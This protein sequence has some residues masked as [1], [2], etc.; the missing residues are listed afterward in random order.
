MK[1]RLALPGRAPWR[2][3]R[4]ATSPQG[5]RARGREHLL[6]RSSGGAEP[7]GPDALKAADEVK[8][9]VLEALEKKAAQQPGKE[10]ARR[11]SGQRTA[12]VTGAI[13]I[14]LGVA[15]LVLVQL[16]DTRG[17]TL[18]PPPPEAYGP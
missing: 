14:F 1:R 10:G 11:E 3:V 13:A 9:R 5:M 12:I 6:V 8:S 18:I 4:G 7:D 16:L 15:Y 17:V 2:R